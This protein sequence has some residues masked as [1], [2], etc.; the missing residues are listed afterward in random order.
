[1]NLLM[2]VLP[3]RTRRLGG[4]SAP[5]KLLASALCAGLTISAAA[6]GLLTGAVE[7]TSPTTGSHAGGA[8]LSAMARAGVDAPEAVRARS[9]AWRLP[10]AFEPAGAGAPGGA[11]YLAR[12]PGYQVFVGSAGALLAL[13]GAEPNTDGVPGGTSSS[14]RSRHSLSGSGGGDS[15]APLRLVQLRFEGARESVAP[16]PEA[17]LPGRIHRLIGSDPA[18]WQRNLSPQ[19]RVRYPDVYSGVDVVYYGSGR[20]LEYDF[21][22]AP[23][24]SPDVARLRFDGVK[25]METD[26]QGQLL[27]DTG[28]GVLVQRAPVAYQ[29][30]PSGR[31]RVQARYQSREDGSVGF[32]VGDYDPRR[33]LVIDPILSYAT[34]LGGLG[35]DECWDVTV[36]ASGAAYV[37]GE[38]ESAS[39]TNIQL[40]TTNV[41][42]ARYQGGLENV[43]GDAFVGKLAPDGG[44]FEWLTY[45]GGSDLETAFTLALGSGGEP[46][47]GGFTSSTNFPVSSNAWLKVLPG[48]TNRFTLRRP[49]AGFV[50]RLK[51]DGSGLV[52]STLLGGDGEDQVL[53]LGVFGDGSVA[54]VGS[55]TSSNFPVTAGAFQSTFGGVRDG[56]V[57]RFSPD[58]SSLL[59]ATYLGGSGWDSLEGL[60]INETAGTLLAA[61][62]TFSTN[63]PVQAALQST[64]AGGAD[65]LLAGFRVADGGADF[66]TYLGGEDSDY[67][68]RASLDGSGGTW[69]VGQTFS[70]NF[71]ATGGIQS[72]NAGGG[73]GFAIRV[74]AGGQSLAYGTFLGGPFEDGLWDVAAGSAGVVHFAGY[75]FSSVF[76]GISTNT[77]LQGT[78]AGGSDAVIARL[79]PAGDLTA[80]Y[81]GGTGDEIGYALAVDAAGSEYV[82][83]RARSVAFPVSSTNVAQAVYGGGRADGFV[84]KL[85]DPPTLAVARVPAGLLLS[86][87]APNSGYV[88]ETARAAASSGSSGVAESWSVESVPAVVQQGRHTVTVPVSSTERVYRLR[89]GR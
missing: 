54:V 11:D 15:S 89:R 36:D 50:T 70:D 63:L 77:S 25:S 72:T 76:T 48:T 31:K 27:L 18:R 53:D 16:V 10:L 6:V 37:A 56:F 59:R 66:L 5:S 30:T 1:M 80:T 69:V 61:G 19:A 60:S 85:S 74:A 87:P 23:G 81:Y 32:V 21:V 58:L 13:S 7:G 83:G 68:Y 17:P 26:S 84:M 82:A 33:P 62:I 12:G 52:A 34:L 65:V 43:A 79:T 3:G 88:V 24:A 35:F 38:T 67:A 73:D 22:F 20:E 46:I 57:A 64:N 55:T 86:W 49:L 47:V 71:P 4:R 75:S 42:L 51:S 2:V 39:F 44:S 45:L 9:G 40:A 41:F 78:N 8:L 29:E 28:R 14:R